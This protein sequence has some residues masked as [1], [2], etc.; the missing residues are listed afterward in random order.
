MNTTTLAPPGAFAAAKPASARRWKIDGQVLG[1]SLLLVVLA[2][3]LYLLEPRFLNR[4]NLLNIARNS[5]FLL[6][7]AS[8]QMLV[9]IVGGY[10]LSVG[11][12]IALSSVVSSTLMTWL[13]GMAPDQP[14]LCILAGVTAGLV[15]AMAAGVLNG[16]CV[17]RLRMP[18]FMVTLGTLSIASGAAFY[19]THGMP[20]YGMPTEF[21]EVFGRAIWIGVPAVTLLALGIVAVLCFVQR[22]TTF[23]RHLYAIGGNAQASRQSGIA[24]TKGLM[25]TY[26]LCAGL[27]G[28]TGILLTA[29]IGSGQAN[30]GSDLMLQSVGA[31]VLAGA[32][33]RGG[34][35]RI[36]RVILSSLFLTLVANGMN[37]LRFESK[38][39]TIVLGVLLIVFVAVAALREK[40]VHYG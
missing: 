12:V 28:V 35:G 4:L 19:I 27:A 20:V 8:G 11:S 34:I 10:D 37:L 1:L 18:P 39:Q 5:S 17:A 13:F 24:V 38:I 3:G 22:S 31:A 30:L 29:R 26:V 40:A 2:V 21:T 6:I 32:S 15:S 33:L 7:V 16:I 9:M 36:E 14:T 23:G 25:W